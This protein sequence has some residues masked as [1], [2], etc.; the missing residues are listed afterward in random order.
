MY[1]CA[2]ENWEAY[3]VETL[4]R[5]V[6]E[7]NECPALFERKRTARLVAARSCFHYLAFTVLNMH[8]GDIARFSHKSYSIVYY[9][10][11]K[12]KENLRYDWRLREAWER[13]AGIGEEIL[14]L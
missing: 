11:T 12:F 9:D 13:C 3:R 5:L 6:G 4:A 14:K 7:A 2:V 8:L 1:I 10:V